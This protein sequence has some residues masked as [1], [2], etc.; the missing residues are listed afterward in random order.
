MSSEDI[1][2]LNEE[3]VD[4]C[5][6]EGAIQTDE[7]Y[8]DGSYYEERVCIWCGAVITEEYDHARTMIV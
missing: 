1:Q 8:R 5:T 2:T 7:E 4:E 6:H 3:P